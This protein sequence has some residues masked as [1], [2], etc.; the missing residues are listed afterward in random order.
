MPFLIQKPSQPKIQLGTKSNPLIRLLLRFP[1]PLLDV[2]LADFFKHFYIVGGTGAGKSSFIS[3]LHWQLAKLGVGNALIDP[4]GDLANHLLYLMAFHPY[5]PNGE[6]WLDCPE[7]RERVIYI[8]P[9]RSD[10]YTPMNVLNSWERDIDVASQLVEAM[11]TAWHKEL[12]I[13]PAFKNYTK[14]ALLPIIEQ[15]LTLTELP[16]LYENSE[17]RD[18]IL[19]SSQNEYARTFFENRFSNWGTKEQSLRLESLLNKVS[20][21]VLDEYIRVVIGDTDNFVNFRQFMDEEKIVI[22]NLASCRNK[23]IRNYLMSLFFVLLKYA[24]SSRADID[25]HH[26][27]PFICTVDEAEIIFASSGMVEQIKEIL[28]EMRKYKLYFGIAHHGWHQLP[29]GLDGAIFGQTGWKFAFKTD[30]KTSTVLADELADPDIYK[31]KNE[32]PHEKAHPQYEAWSD[33]LRSF[34]KD[35]KNLKKREMLVQLPDEDET[36]KLRTIDVPQQEVERYQLEQI[37]VDLL[38]RKHNGKPVPEG[39]KNIQNRRDTLLCEHGGLNGSPSVGNILYD[40][41]LEG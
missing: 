23:D 22:I 33:Q 20:D 25:Q 2:P 29:P 21:M 1:P 24:A 38:Q 27:Q 35:L 10:Y 32:A 17:F 8:E 5:G 28:S 40:A 9:G 13:S 30:A 4:H 15:K 34:A 6:A 31:V 12:Q 14:H 3:G 16:M 26:R 41:S 11:Q 7:N 37:K 19:E 36:I 18:S 39:L